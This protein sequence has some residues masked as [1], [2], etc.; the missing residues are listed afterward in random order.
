MAV[1]MES[2]GDLLQRTLLDSSPI[3][4]PEPDENGKLIRKHH[5]V[6]FHFK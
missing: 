4:E 3:V 1:Y 6:I 2:T 5:P